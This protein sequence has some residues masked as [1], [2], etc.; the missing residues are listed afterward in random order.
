M[1]DINKKYFAGALKNSCPVPPLPFP[2]ENVLRDA[3]VKLKHA[4]HFSGRRGL[5]TETNVFSV[6]LNCLSFFGHTFG[7]DRSDRF[8]RHGLRD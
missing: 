2:V 6:P 7:F 4:P 8:N 3:F 1:G 5:K